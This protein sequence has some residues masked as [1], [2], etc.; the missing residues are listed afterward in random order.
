[1]HRSNPWSSARRRAA[2]ALVTL[3]L[4]LGTSLGQAPVAHAATV[5]ATVTNAK[6]THVNG[7]VFET[8]TTSLDWCVPDGS[9]PGDTFQVVLPDLLGNWTSSFPLKSADGTVVATGTINAGPPS[10][11][12]VTLGESVRG[13]SIDCSTLKLS[14]QDANGTYVKGV[15][16]SRYTVT[17][18]TA[19]GLTYV[20]H[21]L[22]DGLRVVANFNASVTPSTTGAVT[23]TNTATITEAGGSPEPISSRI[24]SNTAIG[25]ATGSS[26]T[27]DKRDTAGNAADTLADAANVP[28]GST[29]IVLTVTNKGLDALHSITVDD[30]TIYGGGQLSGLTCDFSQAVAGA[31]T[32]GTTWAGPW[33]TGTTF[34]C[35]GTLTG[36]T[37]SGHGDIATVSAFDG[38]DHP[39]RAK[40][41][42]YATVKPV[43]VGDHVWWDTNRDGLQTAGDKPV[44]GVV[45]NLLDGNGKVIGTTRTDATGCYSFTGLVP[46]GKYT[47]QSVAPNGATVTRPVAGTNRAV[48][49]NP[50]ANGLAP[51]TAPLTGTNSATRPDEPTIDAG[52]VRYN[53]R[54]AKTLVGAGPYQGGQTVTYTLTPSNDGPSAAL[55]GW[56]VTDVPGADLVVT[57]MK[58]TGYSCSV[59]TRTCT[60]SSMLLPGKGNPI[61]VTARLASDAAGPVANVAYVKPAAGD[62]RETNP[63][64]TPP[65]STT[66]TTRT[67]TDNDARAVLTAVYVPPLAPTT[68][69]WTYRLQA[70]RYRVVVAGNAAATRA[71]GALVARLD[72]DGVLRFRE[73]MGTRCTVRNAPTCLWYRTTS[74]VVTVTVTSATT[75]TAAQ[76]MAAYDAVAPKGIGKVTTTARMRSVT[77]DTTVVWVLGQGATAAQPWGAKHTIAQVYLAH[78]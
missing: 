32:S 60:S 29:G 33:P 26:V 63:L 20:V 11:V 21:G 7:S 18:C 14:W 46:G 42:Y 50:G 34:T 57:G 9:Q 2:M 64:G 47:V 38:N 52:L 71:N 16:A 78:S 76:V 3:S 25:T 68:K 44:S 56:S 6:V 35:S 13:Q 53:L 31:P 39:V 55:A 15:E 54:L 74:K 17:S 8:L 37:P 75:P 22:L 62:V 45:V 4:G 12:T 5:K 1:M 24:V 27:I 30:T 65:S 19:T 41:P 70:D 40:N 73:D 23:Y 48:D 69:T 72:D 43:S 28:T 66:D 51:F 49:S 10:F 67:A 77:R 59:A 58:G 36:V 61:T